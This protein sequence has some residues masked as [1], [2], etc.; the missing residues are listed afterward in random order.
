MIYGWLWSL[1]SYH[2]S[3]LKLIFSNWLLFFNDFFFL[4]NILYWLFSI[5]WLLSHFFFYIFSL[6]SSNFSLLRILST[7]IF[8][9]FLL[10]PIS[11][12]LSFLIFWSELVFIQKLPFNRFILGVIRSECTRLLEIFSSSL[13]LLFIWK[14]FLHKSWVIFIESLRSFLRSWINP[15]SFVHKLIFVGLAKMLW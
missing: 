9:S 1:F 10:F 14:L 12:K 11:Y 3:F 4:L 7:L 13:I 6:I 2:R 8:N 5:L 15:P